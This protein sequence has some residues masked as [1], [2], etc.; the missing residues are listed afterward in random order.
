MNKRLGE[1]NKVKDSYSLDL[2]VKEGV[3]KMAKDQKR[4]KSSMANHILEQAI[5]QHEKKS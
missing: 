2:K 5:E 1:E 3:I 4:S